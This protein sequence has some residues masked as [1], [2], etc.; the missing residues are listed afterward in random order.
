MG[1]YC[2]IC[3]RERPHEQFSGKGRGRVIC[4]RCRKRIPKAEIQR[5][6]ERDEVFGYYCDQSNISAKNSDRLEIL[7]QSP[8]PGIS[9]L[10][11]VV[12]EA[13]KVAPHRR[14]R[15]EVI[16]RERPDLLEELIQC[17]LEEPDAV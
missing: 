9:E 3:H 2:E 11:T 10:A 8:R 14:R 5:I 6:L 4:K 12:L 16:G 13:A 1:R 7:S 17:G 15:R